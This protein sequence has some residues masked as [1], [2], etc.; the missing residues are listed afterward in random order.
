MGA[1]LCHQHELRGFSDRQLSQQ[2]LIDQRKD[3]GIRAYSER[4]RGDRYHGEQ[5]RA[6]ETAA[7]VAEVAEH[8]RHGKLDDGRSTSVA[9]LLERQALSCSFDDTFD[10]DPGHQREN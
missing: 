9:R 6:Q 8:I 5:W 7:S 10:I 4:D 2:N 3:G 1:P